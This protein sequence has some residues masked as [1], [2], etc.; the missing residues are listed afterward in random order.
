MR[1]TEIDYGGAQ[2]IDGYGPGFFRIGGE[3]MSGDLLLLPNGPRPFP[4]WA[5]VAEAK[6]TIDLLLIGTGAEIRTIPD[7]KVALE[8]A[9]MPFELMATAPACRTYNVLLAEGRPLGAVLFAV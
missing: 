3:V 2:P 8:P 4:G 6:E 7:A 9:D 5:E 1:L